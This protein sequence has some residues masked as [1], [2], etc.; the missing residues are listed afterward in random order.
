MHTCNRRSNERPTF[1][2]HER[3]SKEYKVIWYNDELSVNKHP[4]CEVI[5]EVVKKLTEINAA[6]EYMLSTMTQ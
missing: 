5:I 1:R 6:S 4:A 3:D 2:E